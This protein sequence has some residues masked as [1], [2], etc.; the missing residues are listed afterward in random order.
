VFPKIFEYPVS[1]RRSGVN[2]GRL[3]DAHAVPLIAG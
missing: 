3:H 2:A 1:V